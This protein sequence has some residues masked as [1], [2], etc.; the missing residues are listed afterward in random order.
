MIVHYQRHNINVSGVIGSIA[1]AVG[2]GG[3]IDADAQLIDE[4]DNGCAEPTT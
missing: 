3:D 1:G 2:G 4:A